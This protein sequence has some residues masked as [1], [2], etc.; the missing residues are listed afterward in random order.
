MYFAALQSGIAFFLLLR[1][2]TDATLVPRDS[3]LREEI[4]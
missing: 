1:E 4:L 2:D 3:A